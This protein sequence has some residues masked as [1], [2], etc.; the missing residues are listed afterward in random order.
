[1]ALAQC[2]AKDDD[3]K[4]YICMAISRS[5]SKTERQ[6]ASFNS[7][8][9]YEVVRLLSTLQQLQQQRPPGYILENVSP[10]SHRP[11]TKIRD[12]VFPYIASVIGRPVSFEAAQAGAYAHRLRAYWSNL[13]Q[14][15]QFRSVMS[16]V[17]RPEGRIVSSILCK[18]WHP[19]PVIRTD[20]SPHY[21]VN[22]VGE[23]LRAL[24]TIMATQGSRAF[25]R[26]R[27]GTVVRNQDDEDAEEESREVNL[28]EKARA[29]G[30]SASELRM[31]DGL[32]DV[33]LA[34]I[35]G[36]AMDRR[37]MELLM[38]VAEASRKGLPRS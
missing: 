14:N 16:K 33:E 2:W 28:D 30:Y 22:V 20:R 18:G 10:L 24:P 35:L 37:A 19:R 8:L 15:H 27:M 23:P 6:Y 7:K 4:E 21:V 9:F 34:S 38:A 36:L 17:V 29:M 3:G 11:G 13:F 1:M 26:A 12:E 5:L 32:N 25:R 31:A